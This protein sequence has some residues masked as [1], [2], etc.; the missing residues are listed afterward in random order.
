MEK[1]V[2]M[3]QF[4]RYTSMSMRSSRVLMLSTCPPPAV[5]TPR[6]GFDASNW[7]LASEIAERTAESDAGRCCP[8]AHRPPCAL[9]QERESPEG[10]RARKRPGA[11]LKTR[12][13]QGM[14]HLHG[15]GA[16]PMKTVAFNYT[17]QASDEKRPR[18]IEERTAERD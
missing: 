18:E 5:S 15:L 11:C 7:L 4:M 6:D 16:V 10:E 14:R 13:R 9:T 8:P 17:V 2:G 1:K 3:F 12:K